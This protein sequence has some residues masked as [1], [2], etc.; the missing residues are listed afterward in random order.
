MPPLKGGAHGEAYAIDRAGTLIGSY[1]Y[2][3]G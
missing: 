2:A 3:A 1:S